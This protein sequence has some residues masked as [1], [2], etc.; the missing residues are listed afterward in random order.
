MIIAFHRPDDFA[1]AQD[2][3]QNSSNNKID[4]TDEKKK[5]PVSQQNKS[6]S[7]VLQKVDLNKS[8]TVLQ[9]LLGQGVIRTFSGFF[10]TSLYTN[11]LN[12]P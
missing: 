2:F 11:T 3:N 4:T 7:K 5:S 9:R 1:P 10:L 8:Y 6:H 12:Q